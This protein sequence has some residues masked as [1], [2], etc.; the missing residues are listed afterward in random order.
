MPGLPFTDTT[1]V[2]VTFT[3][4]KG[5][6]AALKDNPLILSPDEPDL[7]FSNAVRRGV[8]HLRDAEVV[9]DA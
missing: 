3:T 8:R 1:P 2:R 6:L 9:D 7:Y 4:D 5:A